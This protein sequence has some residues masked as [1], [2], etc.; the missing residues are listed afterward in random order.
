MQSYQLTMF[1]ISEC[2]PYHYGD[3]CA[4]EC[5][6][7][8]GSEYCNAV[9]GCQCKSGWFGLHCDEDIDECSANQALCANNRICV[10]T[11]GSFV[12]QC[13]HGYFN[14]SIGECESMFKVCETLSLF[15]NNTKW[16]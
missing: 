7:G 1:L 14:N 11:H 9:W 10:N 3:N 13:Q 5:N 8:V 16:K 4:L 15:K 6:C 2:D 12:C